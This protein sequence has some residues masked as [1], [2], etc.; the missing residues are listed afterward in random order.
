MDRAAGSRSSTAS[1]RAGQLD[2]RGRGVS[3]EVAQLPDATGLGVEPLVRPG[4]PL[5]DLTHHG[6]AGRIVFGLV[7]I[8]PLAQRERG[9]ELVRGIRDRVPQL[10]DRFGPVLRL[11]EVDLLASVADPLVGRDE[12]GIRPLPERWA[13]EIGWRRRGRQARPGR[14]SRGASS[15]PPAVDQEASARQ[16]DRADDRP[17]P[18]P[19]AARLTAARFGRRHR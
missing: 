18:D 13:A 19:A 3:L 8:E 15:L 7:V 4:G 17:D 6:V 9:R 1:I 11:G 10:A 14:R 2:E 16:Q 12:Q 5:H